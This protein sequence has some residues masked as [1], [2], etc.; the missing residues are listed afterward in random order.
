MRKLAPVAITEL[1][2]AG[3]AQLGAAI[4]AHVSQP[5]KSPR[6][7]APPRFTLGVLLDPKEA[8]PPSDLATIRHFERI[9]EGMGLGVEVIGKKDF[10]RIAEF[11]ALWIRENTNIDHHTFRFAKR[12][13]QEGLPVIDDSELD[14]PLHQQ[15]L[16]GRAAARQRRADAQDGDHLLGQGPGRAARRSSATRWS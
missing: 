15:G 11:D 14:H 3:K 12:A 6:A 8:L 10:D 2:E 4:Q 5:W 9:A 13:E 1:G 7:K 16:S